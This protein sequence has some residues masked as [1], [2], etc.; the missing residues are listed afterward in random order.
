M[1]E[2]NDNNFDKILSKAFHEY[3]NEQL[4]TE[5]AN[6]TAYKNST[7]FDKKINRCALPEKTDKKR[8]RKNE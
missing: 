1:K 4:E 2:M 6:A 3:V 5:A 7:S 8:R